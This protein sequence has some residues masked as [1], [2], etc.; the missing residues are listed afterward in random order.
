MWDRSDGSKLEDLV[1][2]N[3]SQQQGWVT[4]AAYRDWLAECEDTG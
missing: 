3:M 4:A 2:K 1:S